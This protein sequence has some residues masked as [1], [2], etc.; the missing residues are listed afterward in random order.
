MKLTTQ[1]ITITLI[2]ASATLAVGTGACTAGAC[3]YCEMTGTDKYCTICHG[4]AMKGS[5]INRICSGGTTIDGCATYKTTDSSDS[6]TVYCS[7]CMT[8]YY[9]DSTGA[10]STYKCNKCDSTTSWH[11]EGK[12]C[13]VATV[14][15]GCATYQE[16]KDECSTCKTGKGM[17]PAKKCVTAITNCSSHSETV[18]EC[19]KC[20]TGFYLATDKKSCPANIANC[21]KAKDTSESTK[22]KDCNVKFTTKA[23]DETCQAITATNCDYANAD[24]PAECID[25][26]DGYF[27]ASGATTCTAITVANC[28]SSF[29][30]KDAA[31]CDSCMFGYFK[32][33]D[34]TACTAMA[35]CE[36][37]SAFYKT[38]LQCYQCD[39][40]NN[41]FATDI[42]GTAEIVDLSP[43]AWEQV[44]TK[45][46]KI[47]ATTIVAL[48]MIAN[49]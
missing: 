17:T 44:C 1:L 28:R 30:S 20:L 15:D 34:K 38:T 49:F 25:C 36:N 32:K 47:I 31:K 42:K 7:S 13:T 21:S 10:K 43:K 23:S 8:G 46:A 33:E 18:G 29:T 16:G 37:G 27:L 35:S 45:A 48:T 26:A 39:T 11:K 9:M 40:V 6:A 41:Y 5:G 4:S 3:G 24:K 12:T 22:C 14:V 19:S 2:L